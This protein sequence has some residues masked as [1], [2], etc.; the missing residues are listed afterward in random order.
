M[1]RRE[2]LSLAGVSF[3]TDIT[4]VTSQTKA[5]ILWVSMPEDGRV[6]VDVAGIKR[7]IKKELGAAGLGGL[8][9]LL[10]TG[11]ECTTIQ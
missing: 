10:F 4:P 11:I 8:P 3:V 5:L 9:V 6:D 7:E 1:N 2:L